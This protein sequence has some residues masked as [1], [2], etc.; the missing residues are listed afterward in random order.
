MQDWIINIMNQFGY[1]G[2]AF[3][4][5]VENIFPPIPSE[6]ILTFGGFMTTY[7]GFKTWEVILAATV[8]S[9]IGAIILYSVGRLL[10]EEHLGKLLDGR[11]GRILRFKKA[12]LHRATSWFNRRGKITVLFCRCIPVLR[13]LI[14]I[15]AGMA[16]M[17]V[18]LFL[19]YTTIG[20]LVWNTLLVHLGVAAGESWES[21]VAGT[22][23]YAMITIVILILIA[24]VL[25][26]IFVKKRFIKK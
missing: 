14:S 7:S 19:L 20:S 3:L 11:V 16:K 4:I 22:D 12:D 10:S 2:I 13:S 24:A 9:L 8:G 15:P 23:T 26:G 21:I 5:A 18:G 6:V 1:F 25:F 17:K